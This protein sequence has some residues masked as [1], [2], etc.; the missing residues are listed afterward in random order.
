MK[1]QQGEVVQ[2][3]SSEQWRTYFFHTSKMYFEDNVF[4]NNKEQGIIED[5]IHKAEEAIS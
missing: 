1:V 5:V 4:E 2:K 3:K